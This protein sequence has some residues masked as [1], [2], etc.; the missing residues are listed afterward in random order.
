MI[1]KFIHDEYCN[2]LLTLVTVKLI[3]LQGNTLCVIII[4]VLQ[5][6]MCFDDWSNVSMR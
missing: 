4:E 2:M 6:L 1:M 5:V 3:P